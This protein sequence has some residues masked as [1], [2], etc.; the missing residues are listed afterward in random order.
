MTGSGT[1]NSRSKLIL[2]GF[3]SCKRITRGITYAKNRRWKTEISLRR[4]GTLDRAVGTEFSAHSREL[5][6][7]AHEKGTPVMRTLFYEFP[8]DPAAWEVEDEYLYGSNVLV[9]PVLEAKAKTRRVYLPGKGIIWKDA[10]T[11]QEYQGGSWITVAVTLEDM[12]VYIR[13]E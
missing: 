11:G 6:K 4:G 13:K 7:E 9:A 5:M 3:W 12:P 1:G 8:E 10:W 2:L